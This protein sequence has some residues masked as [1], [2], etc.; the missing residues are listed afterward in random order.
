M[1][2]LAVLAL[3]GHLWSGS[4]VQS[5]PALGMVADTGVVEALGQAGPDTRLG[6]TCSP[7]ALHHEGG[8]DV[9]ILENRGQASGVIVAVPYLELW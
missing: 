1:V 8:G 3:G 4:D 5:A 9:F 2:T 6:L 7:V